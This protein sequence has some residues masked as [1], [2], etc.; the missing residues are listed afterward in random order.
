MADLPTDVF[1]EAA[2]G[3]YGGPDGARAVVL[4]VIATNARIAVR[5]A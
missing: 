2:V 1:R 5:Q 4:V 3:Y